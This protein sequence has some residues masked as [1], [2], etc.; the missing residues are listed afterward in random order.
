MDSF[1]GFVVIATM[2]AKCGA[3]SGIGLYSL[4][5]WSEQPCSTRTGYSTPMSRFSV[6]L[7]Q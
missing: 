1:E 4:E 3:E 6:S 2:Y 5:R 7:N